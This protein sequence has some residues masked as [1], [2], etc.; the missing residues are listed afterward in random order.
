[1]VLVPV[2]KQFKELDLKN[3]SARPE[4]ILSIQNYMESMN[5]DSKSNRVPIGICDSIK[6]KIGISR[7]DLFLD[8]NGRIYIQENNQSKKNIIEFSNMDEVRRIFR[9]YYKV[10]NIL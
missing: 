9:L 10:R 7:I 5:E 4:N 1:M 3:I 2:R 8:Q 6:D